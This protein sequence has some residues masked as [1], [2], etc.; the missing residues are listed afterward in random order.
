MA[1]FLNCHNYKKILVHTSKILL[2]GSIVLSKVTSKV[3]L[4]RFN[5]GSN[6]DILSPNIEVVTCLFIWRKEPGPQEGKKLAALQDLGI[7]E[8]YTIHNCLRK[9]IELYLSGIFQV[10]SPAF[11]SS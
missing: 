9:A 7:S 2:K 4:G 1:D 11:Q 3:L 6:L 8:H 10:F 5:L